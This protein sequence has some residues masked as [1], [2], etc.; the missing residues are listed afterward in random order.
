MTARAPARTEAERTLGYIAQRGRVGVAVFAATLVVLAR[1]LT[2]A[3]EG[4][5]I[6]GFLIGIGF[7]VAVLAHE[8]PARL[9]RRG[10]AVAAGV[11]ADLAATSIAVSLLLEDVPLIP[12]ALLW[13]VFTAGLVASTIEVLAVAAFE[14]LAL[15]AIE[16]ATRGAM[17]ADALYT[18]ASWG[19]LYF[20]A[21]FAIAVVLYQFRAAQRATE[22]AMT[23]AAGL[24]FC[25]TP[26]EVGETLFDFLDTLLGTSG[27]PAVLLHDE[28]AAGTHVA[29]AARGIDADTRARLRLVDSGNGDVLALVQDGGMST[30]PRRLSERLALAGP[31]LEAHSLFIVPLR[32]A[33]RTIGALLVACPK[34]TLWRRLCAALDRPDLAADE[35]FAGLARRDANRDELLP[36]LSEAFRARTVAEWAAILS[37]HGVPFAPVND[38]AA[39][40]ADPQVAARSGLIAYEHETL[41]DVRTVASALRVGEAPVQPVPAPRLGEDTRAVLADVCGYPDARLEALE[42]AGVFGPSPN[43]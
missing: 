21:A 14:T 32:D 28:R 4:F 43:R 6:R 42:Q 22:T 29:I 30:D 15:L 2:E 13:P 7:F 27:F 1:Q 40:F 35:R 19:L 11:L 39:A 12:V 10:V 18:T 38:L 9:R 3:P 36:L 25:S 23:H 37:E 17:T 5:L 41:G 8:L 34:E 31:M 33:R 26:E 16:S 24:A 20:V